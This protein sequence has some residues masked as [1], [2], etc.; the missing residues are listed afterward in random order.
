MDGWMGVFVL[1]W[2]VSS[3]MEGNEEILGFFGV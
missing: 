3:W 1:H 2:A